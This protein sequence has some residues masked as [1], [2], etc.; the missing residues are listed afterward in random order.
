M[1]S[2]KVAL[3]FKKFCEETLTKLTNR[4]LRSLSNHMIEEEEKREDITYISEDEFEFLP[5]EDIGLYEPKIKPVSLK[6]DQEKS[7]AKCPVC[8]SESD[9]VGLYNIF[10]FL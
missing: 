1:A 8:L 6:K 7:I 9:E 4:Q 3:Q 5:T 2:K 10:N